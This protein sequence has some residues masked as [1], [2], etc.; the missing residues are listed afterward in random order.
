LFYWPISGFVLSDEAAIPWREIEFRSQTVADDYRESHPNCVVLDDD[1][2]R[3]SV[4]FMGDLPTG[5]STA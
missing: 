3:K 2:R 5:S 4:T 1:H